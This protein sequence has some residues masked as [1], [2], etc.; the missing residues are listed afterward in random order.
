MIQIVG[1]QY[2][3][4]TISN[5][6]VFEYHPSLDY[7]TDAVCLYEAANYAARD[8]ICIDK[9]LKL[10]R[11]VKDKHV[12]GFQLSNIKMLYERAVAITEN[13]YVPFLSMLEVALTMSLS[14]IVG[15]FCPVSGIY[16]NVSKFISHLASPDHLYCLASNEFVMFSNNE[17][18]AFQIHES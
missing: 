16:E 15:E 5:Y 12:V 11:H 10:Y 3:P 9:W 17:V 13:Q 6:G 18:I 14:R 8:I 4:P 2:L 7:C 1:H